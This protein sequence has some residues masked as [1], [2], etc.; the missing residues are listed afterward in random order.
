MSISGHHYNWHCISFIGLTIGILVLD[1]GTSGFTSNTF[2][3]KK[4]IYLISKHKLVLPVQKLYSNPGQNELVHSFEMRVPKCKKRECQKGGGW[5]GGTLPDEYKGWSPPPH[6]W[7]I[8][9]FGVIVKGYFVT[10]VSTLGQTGASDL[11]VH[12]TNSL[13][14]NAHC[15]FVSTFC[16]YVKHFDW[17]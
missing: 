9:N 10:L 13:E 3:W 16:Y 5:G 6:F 8:L 1:K 12:C 17:Q 2:I 15:S 4:Y 14:L 7:L 11:N